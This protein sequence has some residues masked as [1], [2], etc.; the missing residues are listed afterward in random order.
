MDKRL[1]LSIEQ[2]QQTT[3]APMQLQ[4]VRMLEMNGAEVEDEVARALDDNPALEVADE[5]T[6]AD[7]NAEFGETAE[8]LQRADYGADEEVPS[9]RLGVNNRSSDDPV[10]EPVA[11][12]SGES[13][14]EYLMNQLSED[15]SVSDRDMEIARFVVGNIDG[16]GYMERTVGAITDD[17]AIQEGMDVDDSEVN[18]VWQRVRCLEPAGVGAVDLR[19]SLLLQLRRRP[20]TP[21]VELA[22][23]IVE[24]Y[25]DL[26]SLMHF[27]RLASQTG[28]SRSEMQEA[29]D[30][31]RTLNPKPGAL[32]SGD[33]DER[34]RHITPD[35]YVEADGD[36][37][38]LQSLSHIPKLQIERSFAAD[39]AVERRPSAAVEAA[40][41][42]IR[43]K[44]DEAQTF[45]RVVELRNQTLFRVMS[46]IVQWQ[47]EFFLT[48]DRL[49]LRPMVLKDIAAVTGDDI[50]VISRATTGKYVATAQGVFAIKSL[51]SERRHDANENSSSE[52]V[53]DRLRSVI[54][55][56]DKK[57]PLSDAEITELLRAEGID[58]ARRT[59]AKY[60]ERLGIPVGRLRKK[61]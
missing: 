52:K 29:M 26:F 30:T 42:F 46:A 32:V 47:R 54:D 37:L 14:Y 53:L 61:M 6:G 27:D 24:H 19:D 39:T 36:R 18:R 40:N 35:F 48:G 5:P 33:D 3:L 56:E 25:F 55:D 51:F 10:Y 11:V 21:S 57:K 7:E 38:V 9:Y 34:T 17:L 1:N 8:E 4:F 43:Q 28:A 58:I 50:S 49:Q 16:N 60:R 31:I 20:V 41:A 23:E 15:P 22:T 2:R 44:R 45:I 59:V 12:A 13:L